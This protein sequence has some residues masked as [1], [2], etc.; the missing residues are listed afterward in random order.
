VERFDAGLAGRPTL[1]RGTTQKLFAGMGRLTENTVLNLK[2]RSHSVSAEITIPDGGADGVIIAQ[3]GAFAGW[4]LY[5]HEGRL[6]YCYNLLGLD[7]AK[8]SSAEPVP[9]GT[10][11]VR[12]E[13]SYDG[14]GLGRG[15]DVALFVDGTQAGVGRLNGTVPLIFSADET[16][17]VGADTAS[18]VSDDYTPESS[19]FTG[20]IGWVQLDT[21]DDDNDHLITAADRWRVAMARQ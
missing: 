16:C 6:T 14:G 18:P 7:R 10:H 17:D 12:M 19:R 8:T 3:G 21:G 1:I 13:F 20:S 5:L 15:G 11:Q 2:N 9:A 4:S